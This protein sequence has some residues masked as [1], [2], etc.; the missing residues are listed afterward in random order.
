MSFRDICR[1]VMMILLATSPLAIAASPLSAMPGAAPMSCTPIKS[2]AA[3]DMTCVDC[4]V[5]QMEARLMPVA[6]QTTRVSYDD[7]HV[8]MI[9]IDPETMYPPPRAG[10]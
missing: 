8:A 2:A 4:C 9:G 7:T 6:Q 1:I 5:L 10:S 3:T